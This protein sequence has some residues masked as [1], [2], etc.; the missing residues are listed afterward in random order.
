MGMTSEELAEQL[1]IPVQQYNALEL[2]NA[3]KVR[4]SPEIII[5]IHD[6]AVGILGGEHETV[7]NF[8]AQFPLAAFRQSIAAQSVGKESARLKIIKAKWE[9]GIALG[10]PDF[11][12]GALL[13]AANVLTNECANELDI[14]NLRQY[15]VGII[16]NYAH[17]A[18]AE[19][20]PYIEMLFTKAKQNTHGWF[21][22]EKRSQFIEQMRTESSR[23]Q[24]KAAIPHTWKRG[25][26]SALE[27]NGVAPSEPAIILP[28]YHL[29]YAEGIVRKPHAVTFNTI[30][31]AIKERFKRAGYAA[32]TLVNSDDAPISYLT[33][34]VPPQS[35]TGIEERRLI[36]FAKLSG[37]CD[38]RDCP[39]LEEARLLDQFF[40]NI[41]RINELPLAEMVGQLASTRVSSSNTGFERGK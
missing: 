14:P 6:L 23:L 34:T 15:S 18:L 31:M 9:K 41:I 29:Q 10:S 5:A 25:P 33:D 4:I 40:S 3:Q 13:N 39:T 19:P 16:I 24:R 17:A 35:I 11:L 32:I 22:E 36:G 2:P 8:E 38:A 1:G 30:A 21:D 28:S 26:K 37:E 20:S 12:L 27:R 7:T